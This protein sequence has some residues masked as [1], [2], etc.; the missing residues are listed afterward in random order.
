MDYEFRPSRLTR[1]IL[2]GLFAGLI[3]TVASLIFNI[4]YRDATH[5]RPADFINVSSLI[6]ALNLVFLAIGVI[7]FIFLR[8]FRRADLIFMAVF[9]LLTVF[10]V[11][12]G[13]EIQL[14]LNHLITVQFRG[15]LLG[16]ILIS[17]V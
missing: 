11:W 3:A 6:F 13:E 2:T 5:Y 14:S 17:G 12:K 9:V 15:L 10:C 1:A 8:N 4:I 16:I 7:Y